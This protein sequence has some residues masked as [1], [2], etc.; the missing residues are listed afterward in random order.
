MKELL[1]TF[2]FGFL[3][4]QLF[5]GATAV[6]SISSGY[7]TFVTG[8]QSGLVRLFST[9]GDLWFGSLRT[10]V[11]FLFVSVAAGIF[12]HGVDW[13]TLGGLY[14]KYPAGVPSFPFHKLPVFIQ[15]LFSPLNMIYEWW[16]LIS[17]KNLA[18][19]TVGENAAN[20]DP[21]LVPNLNYLQDFYL[22]FAQ[23]F[24]H[25]AYA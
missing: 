22:H 25:M 6:L 14:S 7:V 11:V 10:T 3:M 16:I 2:T 23:F 13:M 8:V 18:S 12:L 5:P 15:L 24:I 4:A 19:V 21:T 1:S 17:R 20:I 9:V